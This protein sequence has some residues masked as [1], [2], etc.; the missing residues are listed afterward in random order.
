M[1]SYSLL[2]KFRFFFI[3]PARQLTIPVVNIEYIVTITIYDKRSP[4]ENCGIKYGAILLKIS[5][6]RYIAK[7]MP[8]HE[9][10][11]EGILFLQLLKDILTAIIKKMNNT[12]STRV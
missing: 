10:I 2:Y 11:I 6:L 8:S 12:K 7:Q 5:W 4:I 1:F 3:T 9:D